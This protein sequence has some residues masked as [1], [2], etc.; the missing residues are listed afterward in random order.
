M[1]AP[2]RLAAGY[3]SAACTLVKVVF[4]IVP[5]PLTAATITSAIPAAIRLYSI[6][7]APELVV[8]ER[9]YTTHGV[10]P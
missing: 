2:A 8:H 7:V 1:C 3:L 9:P 5:M 6:A 4:R 10:L